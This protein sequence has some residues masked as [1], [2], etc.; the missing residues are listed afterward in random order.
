[1]MPI[2]THLKQ[3]VIP[4]DPIVDEKPLAGAI[5][6]PCGGEKFELQFP[7]QTHQWEGETVPCTAQ[8]GDQ[9][10][11]LIKAV[12]TNCRGSHVLL[13]IDFHGWNG[14]VCHDPKQAAVA[15]PTLVAW[16]CLQCGWLEHTARV[17]VQNEG[18][19]FCLSEADGAI[20]DDRWPDAFG[21]LTISLECV[22]CGHKPRTWVSCETM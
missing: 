5:R 7:D 4:D 20:D 12:C 15:R 2:P 8:I 11:F 22:G 9:F 17:E 10:F 21:W 18:K 6:C 1:M 16:K 14:F 13:D 3:C 19:E